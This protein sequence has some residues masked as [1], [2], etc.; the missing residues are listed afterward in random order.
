LPTLPI[1]GLRRHL[2]GEEEGQTT[3]E[4]E[5][6]ASNSTLTPGAGPPDEDAAALEKKQFEALFPAAFMTKEQISNGGFIV[7]FLGK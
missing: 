5:G 7:Y 2:Q 3:G 6:E 1:Q 4:G